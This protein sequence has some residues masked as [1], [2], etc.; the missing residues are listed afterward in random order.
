MVT[1]RNLFRSAAEAGPRDI[2]KLYNTEGQLLNISAELPPNTQV[3]YNR[4]GE[5]IFTPGLFTPE[6]LQA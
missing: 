4:Y 5:A 2:L 1:L 3:Q 6:T